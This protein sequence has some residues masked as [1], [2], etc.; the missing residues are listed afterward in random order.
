MAAHRSVTSPSIYFAV[1]P[2]S[3]QL[4]DQLLQ[5]WQRR[6]AQE[7][8]PHLYALVDCLV[9]PGF[10]DL[11]VHEGWQSPTAI[12]ADQPGLD[13]GR[14]WS[15]SLLALS[16]NT[17]DLYQQVA[18]IAKYCSGKPGLG[19]IASRYPMEVVK[20][21][22]LRLVCVSDGDGSRWLLRFGDTRVW[23]PAD[24]WLTPDQ[25]AYLFAGLDSWM[26]VNR[27]GHLQ[28][29]E[30]SPCTDPACPT[31]VVMDLRVSPSQLSRMCVWG[32]ADSH[33]ARAA[34]IWAK[35]RSPYTPIEQ[36]E[37]TEQCLATLDQLG[38][39]D[40]QQRYQGVRRALLQG[41]S[42][43][44]EAA[45]QSIPVAGATSDLTSLRLPP[46]GY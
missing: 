13:S 5:E 28:T 12:Y 24:G 41:N 9:V 38:I 16:E 4:A 10:A 34:A 43:D 35:V 2:T 40:E 37:V 17:A 26:V 1:A 31:D 6:L 44:N 18:R 11:C 22:L 45:M 20:A 27:Y 25:R 42:S 30:G 33:L 19:F 46:R 15:P 29:F 14:M 7:P 23:P 36:Y 3:P 8:R 39:T 21:Q 32:E